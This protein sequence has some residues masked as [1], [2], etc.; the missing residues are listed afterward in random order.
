M[1][2]GG[3]RLRQGRPVIRVP[4]WPTPAP[5]L[6]T[7][8]RLALPTIRGHTLVARHLRLAKP[9]PA[10]L[11][12]DPSVPAPRDEW[13]EV[14][15][16]SSDT[17]AFHAPGWVDA[18]CAS[19]S[20]SDVTHLFEAASG[21][22][23]LVP[24]VERSRVPRAAIRR[25]SLPYGWGFGGVVATPQVTPDEF[26]A[27]VEFLAQNAVHPLTIR[28]N[29]L[30]RGR[31]SERIPSGGAATVARAAHVLDLDGGFDYVFEKRFKSRA[32][33]AVR[34]AERSGVTAECDTTGRLV[35]VFY[36]LYGKSL[37]RWSRR[38]HLP[39]WL[40]RR[41]GETRDPRQKFEDVAARLGD[42]CRVWVAYAEGRPAAAL[43]C[44]VRGKAASYW[45]GC[46]DEE[47]ASRTRASYLV[48]KLAIEDACGAGCLHYHMGETGDSASLAQFK[49]G[50]GA[51]LHRYDEYR[52]EGAPRSAFE[53]AT[54]RLVS[55]VT[56]AA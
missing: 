38:G 9:V 44:L 53:R 41:S 23:L 33:T 16:S 8:W 56:K 22:R 6:W 14:I 43:I 32:R 15:A 1:A 17:L 18:V 20:W 54:A 3:P 25:A 46:I 36:D 42:A 19:G 28:P 47:I 31:W 49:E 5:A 13:E 27:V 21:G 34:R 40:A 48:Q 52:M 37:K 51:R 30:L 10:D 11:I 35:P 7:S 2:W 24:M 26:G 55:A 45:R 4:P 39:A 29:P 50:F 12:S